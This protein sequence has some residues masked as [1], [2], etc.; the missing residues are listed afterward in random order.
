MVGWCE[1][2]RRWLITRPM[3]EDMSPA[4]WFAALPTLETDRIL[5]RPMTMRDAQDIFAY[6]SD[7]EVA[8]HVL[9]DAHRTI[10][11]TRSYL[12]CILDQYRR[13]EA[14]SFCIVLKETGHVV[15]TIGFMWYNNADKAA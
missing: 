6:A 1:R 3:R 2:L 11:D 15:G 12:R 13:G 8:R 10:R 9:W 14:S 4:D 5:L 7:P